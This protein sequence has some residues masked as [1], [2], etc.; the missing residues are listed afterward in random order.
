M[1]IN[2]GLGYFRRD[3]VRKVW[4]QCVL[5]TG[6]T[7]FGVIV[8][9]AGPLQLDQQNQRRLGIL[10]CLPDAGH[11]IKRLEVAFKNKTPLNPEHQPLVE[12]V[13]VEFLAPHGD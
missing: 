12:V 8:K 9:P 6:M 13:S 10:R 5:E 7:V 1:N 3:P 2:A 11:A 4:F